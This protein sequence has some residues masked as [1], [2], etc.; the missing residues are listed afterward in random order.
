MPGRNYKE[1][2]FHAWLDEFVEQRRLD[3]G[4]PIDAECFR[5]P[6]RHVVV[7]ATDVEI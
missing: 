2:P 4:R 5:T 6:T 7:L 3:P 1:S